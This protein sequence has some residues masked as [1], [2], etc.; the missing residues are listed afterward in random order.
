MK[1]RSGLAYN[2]LRTWLTVALTTFAVTAAA[3]TIE[4][5]EQ[6]LGD[7]NVP[8]STTR[9]ADAAS[10][11]RELRGT[12]GL[13]LIPESTN[14]RVMAFD[15]MTGDLVDADFIPADPDNL[16]TPICAIAGFAPDTVLVSDQ[17][18]D[19]VQMYSANDGSYLGVFAPAGGADVSILDNIRGIAKSAA[20]TLLVSVGGGT[21]EDAIAEFDSNG[22]YLGNFVA[23]GAGGLDSPFDVYDRG[24]DYLVAGI[25]SDN[26]LR[27]DT[28]GAF[29]EELTPVDNFPEQV[30]EAA[31]GNI[32]VGNFS[33]G[34]EGVIEFTST[35]TLI[36]VYKP[37]SLSGFRGA[38]DLPNGNILTTNGGG[39]HEIDRNGNLVE[40]KIDGVNAR[41]IEFLGPS[42]TCTGVDAQ[43]EVGENMVVS[44]NE[45]CIF[46]MYITNCSDNPADWDLVLSGIEIGSDGMVTTPHTVMPDTCYAITVSGSTDPLITTTRTVPVLGPWGLAIMVA[47]L[48]GAGIAVMRQRRRTA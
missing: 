44:G 6:G 32:L 20:D 29:I 21:N 34:Q 31:G 10:R 47:L 15:P 12:T 9:S 43:I 2:R 45:G 26:L 30:N 39:V 22:N 28:N 11:A 42:I 27:Y 5:E 14:D 16:S 23:N 19:V 35:G 38:Y 18:D 40:T 17:I 33:G 7:I 46:D 25:T 8:T 4:Q 48:L 13:L 3:Q 36:G 41:F 24:S 1:D 37:A